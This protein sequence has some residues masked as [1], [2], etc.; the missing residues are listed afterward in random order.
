MKTSQGSDPSMNNARIRIFTN[1]DIRYEGTLYK[2]NPEEKTITLKGVQS[3]G[4]ENRR[5]DRHQ[6]ASSLIYEYIVFRSIEIKDL[7]VLKDEDNYSEKKPEARAE[8][9]VPEPKIEKKPELV[10]DQELVKPKDQ[11]ETKESS[12]KEVPAKKKAEPVE[13]KQRQPSSQGKFEFDKIFDKLALI[14]EDKNKISANNIS[15]ISSTNHVTT[16]SAQVW[17]RKMSCT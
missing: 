14:E 13:S 6:P 3:F 12:V 2:I 1:S 5:P 10:K 17:W 4:T 15:S 9:P 16:K 8:A 7:I 11:K